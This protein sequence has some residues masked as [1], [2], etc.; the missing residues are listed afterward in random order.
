MRQQDAVFWAVKTDTDKFG[1]PQYEA[2]VE[3]K[4][5]W[6]DKAAKFE[7]TEGEELVSQAIVYVDRDTKPGGY[8][9]LGLLADLDG[10]TDPHKVGA[11]K[12]RRFDKLPD[13]RN[14]N[15][16]LTAFL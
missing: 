14:K 8:L 6:E 5:R 1:Q 11:T 3:I 7:N 16:L 9:W 13:I 10:E 15:T 2:P 4:C 12:I